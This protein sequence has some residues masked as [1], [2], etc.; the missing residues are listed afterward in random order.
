MTEDPHQDAQ[1][2]FGTTDPEVLRE[3]FQ[4]SYRENPAQESVFAG[5]IKSLRESLGYTVEEM[6]KQAQI[7]PAV[8]T[9]WEANL[10]MPETEELFATLDRIYLGAREKHRGDE[11]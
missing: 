3:L 10:Q 9:D 4:R 7:A 5:Y 11:I 1:D 2:H 6:A 8:W